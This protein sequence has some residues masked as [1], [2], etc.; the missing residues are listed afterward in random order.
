MKVMDKPDNLKFL[1]YTLGETNATIFTAQPADVFSEGSTIVG[2][3]VYQLTWQNK[4]GLFM[5]N[6]RLNFYQNFLILM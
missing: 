5:I 4:K 3:K 1:K 2:N 6:H